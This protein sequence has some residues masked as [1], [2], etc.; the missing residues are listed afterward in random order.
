MTTLEKGRILSRDAWECSQCHTVHP[1][2]SGSYITGY[3]VD[4]AGNKICFDCC[5]INDRAD[6]LATGKAT[7]YL[8]F[9]GDTG[10]EM[11][12]PRWG[13]P[14]PTWCGGRVTNWPGTLAFPC[15][16]KR[17]RH[18]ITGV[19][20]DVWF[21]GPDGK[22]WHGVTYG[23]MT[24]LCHCKRVQTTDEKNAKLRAKRKQTRIA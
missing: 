24:Q 18:N 14:Q 22:P 21:T 12:K 23:D 13:G 5:A 10:A 6:M 17:G 19:R 16:V 4:K 11:K 3:G 15:H 7:L 2:E 9:T 1:V 20:Y 8:L